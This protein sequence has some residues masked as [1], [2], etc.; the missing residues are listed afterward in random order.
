[1]EVTPM[2][3]WIEIG[4]HNRPEVITVNLLADEEAINIV[5]KSAQTDWEY[6]F[7]DTGQYE[8]IVKDYRAQMNAIILPQHTDAVFN[9]IDPTNVQLETEITGKKHWLDNESES[10]PDSIVVYLFANGVLADKQIVTAHNDWQYRFTNVPE[11]DLDREKIIYTI[12]EEK[13][14]GYDTSHEGYDLINLRVGI[15]EVNIL[16]N[17]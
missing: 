10:R 2:K 9:N 1:M 3:N 14:E 15:T 7:A 16:K 5:N 8:D 11:Y 12:E 17:G 4:E 13:I 6:L